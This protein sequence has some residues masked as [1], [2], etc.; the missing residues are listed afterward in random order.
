M[1]KI[2]ALSL[3]AAMCA[4]MGNAAIASAAEAEPK[5]ASFTGAPTVVKRVRDGGDLPLS[6]TLPASV[7]FTLNEE[8]NVVDASGGSLGGYAEI[9]T[10][11]PE[12]V[13]PIAE[14]NS[15]GA[16][17]KLVELQ[18]SAPSPSDMAVMSA[19]AELLGFVRT[20]LTDIRGIY[21]CTDKTLASEPY[22]QVREATEGMANVVVL[23]EEQS[24]DSAVRYFQYRFKTV[25]TQIGEAHI[26]DVFAVHAAVAS[27]AYGLISSDTETVFKAYADYNDKSVARTPADIA[28]RGLPHTHAENSL[29]GMIAAAD[30]GATHLEIDVYLTKD[31]EVVVMH[32]GTIDRTTDGKGNIENMTLAEL[33]RYSIVRTMDGSLTDPQPIPTL[34]DVMQTFADRDVIL[35]CEVKSAKK[36]IFPAIEEVANTYDF[37]DRLVFITFGFDT[38]E[39]AHKLLPQVPA[40]GLDSFGALQFEANARKY[41]RLNAVPD[42]PLQDVTSLADYYERTMKDCGYMSFVWTY[43]RAPMC[44]YAASLGV[45][46]LT[47][48]EADIFAEENVFSVRGKAGQVWQEADGALQKGDAVRVIVRT[49][50]GDEI[51]LG[52]KVFSV[53]DCG[54]YAEVVASY[55][56]DMFE[57]YTPAFRIDYDGKTDVGGQGEQGGEQDGGQGDEDGK[58]ETQQEQSGCGGVSAGAALFAAAAGLFLTK[59]RRE[60][61]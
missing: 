38:L 34:S 41:N 58:D 32:D 19:S 17:R 50:F 52:G 45:F 18:E 10:E 23:S 51:E 29:D 43:D 56:E 4:S 26:K 37:W 46:G 48:N 33:R 40:A 44:R 47:N 36:D 31:G 13:I 8:G 20:E 42:A 5:A 11:L 24:T 14:V 21:D 27:G 2:F 9:L 30:A 16:A 59:K 53:R 25:W 3:A 61:I 57:L 60:R 39:W 35:V 6:G 55:E 22:A 28:H 12:S 49:Y 1:K 7:I 15:E 54:G